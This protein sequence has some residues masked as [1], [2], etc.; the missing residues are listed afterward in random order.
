MSTQDTAALI[1]SVNKMTDT[2]S[3]KVG[4]IDAKSLELERRVDDSLDALNLRLPRLLVTK[5]MQMMDGNDDGLPDDWGVAADVDGELIFSVVQSSQAAG[6]TQAV[7]DMLDEI[8][9]DIREVYPDFDIR[10]SEYYRVPFNVWRF[11]WSTK[12]TSWLAYPY[13][14]DVGSVG[15]LSVSNNSYVT[16][17]AFVRV[18]SG[19]SWG[20][21]CNGSTIGKWR[22]CSFVVEPTGEFGAYT[23]SHPYRGTDEGVVEVALAGVC[24]G[25]VDHPS[26]WF[27]MY[28]S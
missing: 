22:W 28:Q 10:S 26:Q 19:S 8:E 18:V 23:V 3:G 27:S 25:V 14:S 24:T 16:M 4:E 15:S 13:S 7:V 21:W 17:G 20:R 6:R 2:V 9:R 1:E 5:N 12:N 11:S